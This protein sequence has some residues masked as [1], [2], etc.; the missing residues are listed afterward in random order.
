MTVNIM[1]RPFAGAEGAG[2]FFLALATVC[3]VL[4]RIFGWQGLTWLGV[5][6]LACFVVLEFSRVRS[7]GRIFMA[8][9]LVTAGIAVALL[10]GARPVIVSALDQGLAFTGLLV[11]LATLRP[12]MQ[13]SRLLA[14]AAAWLI[15]RPRGFRYVSVSFG[16]HFLA[17]IFNVGVLQLIGDILRAARLEFS[18]HSTARHLLLGAMRGSSAIAIWSPLA[19]GFAVVTT[20]FPA[21]NPITYIS[22]GLGL[23]LILLTMGSLLPRDD[24]NEDVDLKAP[25]SP[26]AL[27]ILL[28]GALALLLV[29]SALYGLADLPFLTATTLVVPLF[30]LAWIW[31]EPDDN[32]RRGKP[33]ILATRLSELRN[34]MF[35]FASSTVIGAL[36]AY[37]FATYG[38][39]AIMEFDSPLMPV[40]IFLAIWALAALST[41]PSIPVILL[42]QLLAAT[43]LAGPHALSLSM[44][45]SAGWAMGMLVSPVSA[46]LLLSAQLAQVP[47]GRIA[48]G[49]NRLY[50]MFAV[51]ICCAGLALIYAVE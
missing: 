2:R 12:A 38:P 33:A 35:I 30:A 44:A 47:G 34:E 45:L 20:A 23:T 1:T 8:T 9:A 11:A 4:G 28:T 22:V 51:P 14:T 36:F 25:D 26:R 40:L 43:S 42:A 49:W 27:L 15:T 31:V 16:A 32:G 21:L 29:T 17:L 41:P 10:P 19:M 46:T 18:R 50:T 13:R 24:L 5:L 48:W 39:S 37:V 7:S 6:A 3:S